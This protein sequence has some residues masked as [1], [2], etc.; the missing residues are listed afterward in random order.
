MERMT[1]TTSTDKSLYRILQTT[2]PK[3]RIRLSSRAVS[4]GVKFNIKSFVGDRISPVS[5]I[6]NKFRNMDVFALVDELDVSN[7]A[8]FKIARLGSGRVLIYSAADDRDQIVAS[9]GRQR[10]A[11][12]AI[13][14]ASEFYSRLKNKKAKC[15]RADRE[16]QSGETKGSYYSHQHFMRDMS[17][18]LKP[19]AD[20]LQDRYWLT[21]GLNYDRED[22]GDEIPICLVDLKSERLQL[23]ASL[24]SLDDVRTSAGK[25]VAYD[26]LIVPRHDWIR[27]RQ[28]P[29]YFYYQNI[30]MQ[31]QGERGLEFCRRIDPGDMI[32]SV[33]LSPDR[34]TF[35]IDGLTADGQPIIFERNHMH[36][37]TFL[38]V[39][40]DDGNSELGRLP[41]EFRRR[42]RISPRLRTLVNDM[43]D[44][45]R[46]QR[47]KIPTVW[48]HEIR[49]GKLMLVAGGYR[50]FSWPS[51]WGPEDRRK[52]ALKLLAGVRDRLVD[53]IAQVA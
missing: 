21:P 27:I 37:S 29:S 46:Q 8:I 17:L 25:I 35:T 47:A 2:N 19:V 16:T 34:Q 48:R 38:H 42:I 4:L 40:G 23:P 36:L 1:G 18:G 20:G 7:Y 39:I 28:G 5:I 10:R 53:S 22:M 30:G 12:H 44:I 24:P 3:L 51:R 6:K 32:L 52:R 45:V 26:S 41:E 33:H 31:R 50:L 11:Q 14:A 15:F 43:D 9:A 13:K 49:S